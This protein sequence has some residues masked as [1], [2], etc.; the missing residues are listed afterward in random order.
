MYENTTT[1]EGW[2]ASMKTQK[3][4]WQMPELM[5]HLPHFP[6]QVQPQ[7]VKD[8]MR[9]HYIWTTSNLVDDYDNTRE[10]AGL[11]WAEQ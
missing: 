10:S 7:T 3:Q 1:K 8:K 11:F 9:S 4:G 5:T 2:G 6:D